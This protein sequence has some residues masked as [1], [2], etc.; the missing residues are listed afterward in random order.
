MNNN[1]FP[2]KIYGADIKYTQERCEGRFCIV[3]LSFNQRAL[4]NKTE[5]LFFQ[6]KYTFQ[7]LI[8]MIKLKKMII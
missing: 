5:F 2:G 1:P 4:E 7:I 6:I 8:I 3:L